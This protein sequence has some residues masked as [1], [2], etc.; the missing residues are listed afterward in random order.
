MK[1]I[2]M[3][4]LSKT[5]AS[6]F[7]GATRLTVDAA[8]G[9]VDLVERVH[10]TIQVR[11]GP[12]GPAPQEPTDGITG[13]IY[14]VVRSGVHMVGWGLDAALDG[15]AKFL[16]RAETGPRRDALVAVANG[17]YGDYLARTGNPLASEMSFRLR[18]LPIDVASPDASILAATGRPP[19]GKLVVLVHGLC[20][21]DLQWR[22]NEHDHGE[23]LAAELGVTVIYL[24]YNSGLHISE[25]GGTFSELLETLLEHWP[26]PLDELVARSAC[27]Y[28][29]RK[30]LAWPKRLRKLVFLGTPHLGSPLERGGRRLDQALD[31]SPYSAPLT[32]LGKSRSAGIQDLRHGT[33]TTGGP[34]FVPLPTGVECYA[35]AAT[36]SSKGSLLADRLIGDGLVPLDSALGRHKD[37]ARTLH[38]KKSH[39]WIAY[40]T[41][42]LELLSSPDVFSQ[43][44]KWLKAAD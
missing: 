43:L 35:A 25:N 26:C 15:A 31:L 5:M 27:L 30:G 28:A 10:R 33:L 11:P 1:G 4:I 42:H 8:V 20:L 17:I 9:A 12:F 32:R 6:D 44:R 13:R 7:R 22:R 34:D 16:P 41:G 38:F 29:A 21:N 40:E 24:R 14:Q 23:A 18:G 3:T 19:T 36:L 39:Q 37:A 2:A